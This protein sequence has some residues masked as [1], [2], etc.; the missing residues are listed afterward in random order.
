M[1]LHREPLSISVGRIWRRLTQQN[2]CVF[3][4]RVAPRQ[5]VASQ[6]SIFAEVNRLPKL[7]RLTRPVSNSATL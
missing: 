6:A 3:A 2:F 4:F 7:S 5:A 1:A